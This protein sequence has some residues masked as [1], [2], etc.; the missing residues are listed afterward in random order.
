MLFIWYSNSPSTRWAMRRLRGWAE[1]T[2]TARCHFDDLCCCSSRAKRLKSHNFGEPERIS[3]VISTLSR[4]RHLRVRVLSPQPGSPCFCVRQYGPA[5]I[6]AI[7]R[8]LRDIAPSPYL[9]SD[10]EDPN[11]GVCLC[12][13]FLVS[14][15]GERSNLPRTH[16]P[17]L[18][19]VASS[20]LASSDNPVMLP[21]GRG[22]LA[23]CPV[24]GR[25]ISAA[26]LQP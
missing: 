16:A 2:R 15:F 8:Q 4:K 22:R 11:S 9:T 1:R 19:R 6:A 26:I 7:P 5:E 25:Q 12:R 24:A 13:P 3:P 10:Y 17:D 21:P 18:G 20:S 14:R 23:T